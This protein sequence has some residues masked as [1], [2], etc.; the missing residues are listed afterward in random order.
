[1]C[2]QTLLLHLVEKKATNRA[3]GVEPV[4]VV[5]I[6]FEGEDS[7]SRNATAS[8]VSDFTAR[9]L[10]EFQAY[11]LGLLICHVG[12]PHFLNGCLIFLNK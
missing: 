1:M 9:L 11:T 7:L 4:Q 12:L 5:L 10:P 3:I 8:Q 6:L 2:H